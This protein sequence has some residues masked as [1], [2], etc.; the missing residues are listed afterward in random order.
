MKQEATELISSFIDGEEVDPSALADALASSGAREILIDFVL[1]RAAAAGIDDSPGEEFHSRMNPVLAGLPAVSRPA[2]LWLPAAAAAAVLVI[3]AVGL[4]SLRDGGE[5]VV[6][7]S[8]PV[9]AR[10]I[11]FEPG[12]DWHGQG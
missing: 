12:V 8:P 11:H 4:W 3:G 1:L 2:R 5:P 7:P 10:T 6:E 9:P